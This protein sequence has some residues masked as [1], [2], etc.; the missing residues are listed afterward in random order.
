MTIC[1]Q[2]KN[3]Y[4]RSLR[5]SVRYIAPIMVAA[6][7]VTVSVS[8][9]G[10][11]DLPN[12]LL[13][14][15]RLI[16]VTLSGRQVCLP[17]GLGSLTNSIGTGIVQNGDGPDA[18]RLDTQGIYLGDT[19]AG[20]P[21]PPLVQALIER[22]AATRL[23]ITWTQHRT[24]LDMS[25]PHL[26]DLGVGP[27]PPLQTPG[28]RDE[29]VEARGY[30]YMAAGP[31][32]ALFVH[33]VPNVAP[34]PPAILVP[35]APAQAYGPPTAMVPA[36]VHNS[37]RICYQIVPDRV[38]EYGDPVDRGN[39]VHVAWAEIL[40]HPKRTPTW[41][42]DTRVLDAMPPMKLDDVRLIDFRNDGDGWR[43]D[44]S[45]IRYPRDGKIHLVGQD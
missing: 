36:G 21:P 6:V 37:N 13:A 40:F 7:V 3:A 39:G 12:Q 35:A 32:A 23:Q 41:I 20:A 2:R 28:P 19:P 31:D 26:A 42:A 44:G 29:A 30:A 10:A 1:G 16:P 18:Y 11:D 4:A 25:I 14:A 15:A 8:S 33:D 9:A 5:L 34:T 17:I 24:I 27:S 45:G 43:P 22:D 38:L